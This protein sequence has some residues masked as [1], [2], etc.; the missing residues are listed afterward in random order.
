MSTN[1]AVL[2]ERRALSTPT[3]VGVPGALAR[4][5]AIAAILR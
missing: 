4:F 1:A 5:H 2:Q 3:T